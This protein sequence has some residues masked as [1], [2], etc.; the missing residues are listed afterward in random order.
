[1]SNEDTYTVLASEIWWDQI[2]AYADV[3]FDDGT[4]DVVGFTITLAK[5]AEPIATLA[6]GKKARALVAKPRCGPS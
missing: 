5:I 3:E 1:M 2:S 4:T 6:T